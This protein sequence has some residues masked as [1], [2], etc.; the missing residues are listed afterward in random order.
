MEITGVALESASEQLRITGTFG[1]ILSEMTRE[2][3]LG[4]GMLS[5]NV[6]PTI[7]EGKLEE[8]SRFAH[9]LMYSTFPEVTVR[10]ISEYIPVQLDGNCLR[11]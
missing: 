10:E 7:R 5:R 11:K 6:V 1:T 4:A 9:S 3:W 8:L 2:S